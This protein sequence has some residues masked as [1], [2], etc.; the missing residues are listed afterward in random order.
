MRVICSPLL[1]CFLLLESSFFQQQQRRYLDVDSLRHLIKYSKISSIVVPRWFLS[2]E[3]SSVAWISV[4]EHLKHQLAR[5]T[6]LNATLLVAVACIIRRHNMSNTCSNLNRFYSH[7][8]LQHF[9]TRTF[10]ASYLFFLKNE[11]W[12]YKIS[13][14]ARNMMFFLL[15]LIVSDWLAGY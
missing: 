10:I 3:I 15:R 14:R 2:L 7:S 9:I 5:S 1:S 4:S 11:S 13:Q 8:S 6:S 12:N